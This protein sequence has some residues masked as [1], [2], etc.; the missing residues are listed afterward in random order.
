MY[1]TTIAMIGALALA[2]APAVAQSFP[3]VAPVEGEN[4]IGGSAGFIAAALIAGIAAI[5][6]LAITNDDDVSPVSP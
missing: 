4:E 2:S 1:K 3:A 6:V 5:G